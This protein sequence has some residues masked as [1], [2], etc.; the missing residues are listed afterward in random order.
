MAV[1]FPP[2]SLAPTD[3]FARFRE[4]YDLAASDPTT[5]LGVFYD[6]HVRFEQ[7]P[8]SE[9]EVFGE[10]TTAE[11][12]AIMTG[13]MGDLA[14][15]YGFYQTTDPSPRQDVLWFRPVEPMTLAAM[16]VQEDQATEAVAELEIPH[17]LSGGAEL[18]V[19]VL[20]PDYPMPQGARDLDEAT[21][22]W[23]HRVEAELARHRPDRDFLLLTLGTNSWDLPSR[24]RGYAWD[25]STHRLRLL[26]TTDAS[27]SS[28]SR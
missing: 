16:I 13:L 3:W 18:G 1:S 24:W 8:H 26:T 27:Q 2:E 21:E 14:R 4:R 20:Y 12:N 28:A 11:W 23:K 25:T 9:T 5:E 17:V 7:G 6:R 15:E 22:L 19:L 10:Y